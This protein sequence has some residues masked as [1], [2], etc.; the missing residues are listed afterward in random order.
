MWGVLCAQGKYVVFIS[1]KEEPEG[2]GE[3]EGEVS[4]GSERASVTA[5]LES[6]T[7]E[8]PPQTLHVLKPAARKV[9]FK[10]STA[11]SSKAFEFE[12]VTLPGTP[13]DGKVVVNSC[14]IVRCTSIDMG[15]DNDL[16]EKSVD[17]SS[18]TVS[19]VVDSL[20][21]KSDDL[22]ASPNPWLELATL[23]DLSISLQDQLNTLMTEYDKLLQLHTQAGESSFSDSVLIEHQGN[24]GRAFCQSSTVEI[25]RASC[26][27][28]V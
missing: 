24:H 26:R 11:Q 19:P 12:Q 6:C 18:E 2:N 17:E 1:S 22:I 23:R 9:H 15:D 5:S 10:S 28:R 8:R 16:P 20:S 14:P 3:M 27:E 21:V 4:E 25:G 7:E 13:I